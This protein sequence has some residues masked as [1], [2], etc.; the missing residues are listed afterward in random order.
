MFSMFKSF[1]T[2]HPFK[3]HIARH[4]GSIAPQGGNHGWEPTPPNNSEKNILYIFTK[5]LCFLYNLNCRA[6]SQ[7]IGDKTSRKLGEPVICGEVLVMTSRLTH[8]AVFEHFEVGIVDQ[9]AESRAGCFANKKKQ[10][11]YIYF[12]SWDTINIHWETFVFHVCH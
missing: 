11:T 2:N 7:R 12:L 10:G 9:S 4:H 3:V 8:R 5:V 6:G 1:A